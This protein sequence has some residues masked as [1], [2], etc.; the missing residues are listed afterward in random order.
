M[1]ADEFKAAIKPEEMISP[2]D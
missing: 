2:R 1:T